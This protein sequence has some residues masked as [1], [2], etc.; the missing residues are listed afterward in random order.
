MVSYNEYYNTR[1]GKAYNVDG[2]YGAQCWDGYADY[3]RY[4]GYPFANCSVTG[5]V[6]DIWNYRH[7]NGTLNNFVEVSVMQPGDVAVF[8]RHPNT[9]Y[10][11][12]AIF[13]GDA[14]GGY[15]WFLGQNQAN[16]SLNLGSGFSLA[17]LPYTATFDTAFRPK[18]FATDKTAQ[19]TP[20]PAP[21]KQEGGWIT[22]NAIFTAGYAIYAR[23]SGPSVNNNSPYMFPKGAKIKYDAYCHANG[24]V[25]IRQKRSNGG[26]WFIPTG[27]SNGSQRTG[28]A[29]GTFSYTV[30]KPT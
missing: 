22:Q 2:Y 23:E 8:K 15:G 25:W 24:F 4:L 9:P 26:Y 1:I 14:G 7:S 16:S 29:W 27:P 28:E 10:S 3:C 5:F 6:Q 17:K 19:A 11:H 20:K 18:R 13:H 12:I 30:K 21:A